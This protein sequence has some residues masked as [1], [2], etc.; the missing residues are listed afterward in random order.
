[1]SRKRE[2][3]KENQDENY[4]TPFKK[5]R[6]IGPSYLE[7]LK[8]LNKKN[9][10]IEDSSY[11]TSNTPWRLWITSILFIVS[12]GVIYV[13]TCVQAIYCPVLILIIINEL[14]L[15]K[16]FIFLKMIIIIR[17][18]LKFMNYGFCLKNN[19]YNKVLGNDFLRSKIEF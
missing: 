18:M 6:G 7:L 16:T 15:N 4:K 19:K 10:K 5:L 2:K 17:T 11:Y 8:E 1:M 14:N 3:E 12:I 9:S 13:I